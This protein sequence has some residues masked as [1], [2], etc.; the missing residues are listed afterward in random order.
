MFVDAGVFARPSSVGRSGRILA[1]GVVLTP[2]GLTP[3]LRDLLACIAEILASVAEIEPRGAA[4]HGVMER[5][6]TGSAIGRTLLGVLGSVAE[7][8]HETIAQRTRAAARVKPR[9]GDAHAFAFSWLVAQG[10]LCSSVR[11]TC[12]RR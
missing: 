6:D 10:E 3:S 9:R 7:W 4:L 2:D 5:V 12:A 1:G 8:E 11:A